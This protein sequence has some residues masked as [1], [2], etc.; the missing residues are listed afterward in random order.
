[1]KLYESLGFQ[2]EREDRL[3]RFSAISCADD[4]ADAIGDRGSRRP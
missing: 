4:A 1:M 2:L 3:V